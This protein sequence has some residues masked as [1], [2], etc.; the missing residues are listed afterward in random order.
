MDPLGTMQN[1]AGRREGNDIDDLE[2]KR[3]GLVMVLGWVEGRAVE[4][5]TRIENITREI[6]S[7]IRQ[8]DRLKS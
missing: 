8:R 3:D 5:R 1:M 7:E 2:K 6:S 4:L